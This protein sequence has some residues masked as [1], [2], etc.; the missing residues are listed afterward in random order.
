MSTHPCDDPATRCFTFHDE[1]PGPERPG[2]R[3]FGSVAGSGRRGSR[4]VRPGTAVSTPVRLGVS[5]VLA[6]GAGRPGRA[7]AGSPPAHPGTV[8]AV[9]SRPENRAPPRG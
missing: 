8:A 5:S 6:G 9:G 1:T 3:R 4:R 7:I 2:R